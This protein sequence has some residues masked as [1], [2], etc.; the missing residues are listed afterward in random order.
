LG[1][2]TF[3]GKTVGPYEFE[4]DGARIEA[5]EKAVGAQES[6]T[7]APPTFL[8]VCRQGEFDLLTQMEISLS[9]VLHGEQEYVS[10]EALLPG[11][12]LSYTTRLGQATVKKIGAFLI[13][14]TAVTALRA[15]AIIEVGTARTTIMVRG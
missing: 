4:A 3:V 6:Q 13:F 2:E 11:D 5:F 14:E 9:Q 10:L 12:R 7:G 8:T 15:S 1:L